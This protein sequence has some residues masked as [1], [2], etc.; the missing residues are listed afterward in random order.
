MPEDLFPDRTALIVL[1]KRHHIKR[2]SLFGSF[3]KGAARPDSN[4]D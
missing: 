1:C 4:V 2:L 3:V